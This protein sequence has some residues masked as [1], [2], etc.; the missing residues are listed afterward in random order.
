MPKRQ[1]RPKARL[2][3]G[4]PRS[5]PSLAAEHTEA[6]NPVAPSHAQ[7]LPRG[8]GLGSRMLEGSSQPMVPTHSVS[9]LRKARNQA[10]RFVPSDDAVTIRRATEARRARERRKVV[11]PRLAKKGWSP[12]RLA[13]DAG[14]DHKTVDNYLNGT[15]GKLRADQRLMLAK[16][17]GISVHKLPQ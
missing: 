3:S 1:L 8:L 12:L 14:T 16:A 7:S 5:K 2:E 4:R 13:K 17:L 9:V 11:D 6:P 10:L 15:T